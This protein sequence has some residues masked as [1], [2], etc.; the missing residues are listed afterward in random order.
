MRLADLG[1]NGTFGRYSRGGAENAGASA[2]VVKEWRDLRGE[3]G[4]GGETEGEE[5]VVEDPSSNSSESRDLVTVGI[6]G[7]LGKEFW[8]G[9]QPSEPPT[10]GGGMANFLSGH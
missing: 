4:K 9:S 2:L 3:T 6:A 8:R 7:R 10:T 1:N 5:E